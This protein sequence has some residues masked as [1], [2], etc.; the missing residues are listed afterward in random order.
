VTPDAATD[1]TATLAPPVHTGA[2]RR[3]AIPLYTLAICVSG[4]VYASVPIHMLGIIQAQGFSAQAA[5]AVAMI[6]GPA[7]VLSRIVEI[8]FG[9]RFDALVTG[10]VALAMLVLAML[11][12]GTV[13]GSASAI[14]FAALYGV[15]QGLITI[16]RGTVPLFLFGP[17]GYG[18]LVGRVTGLRLIVNAAG[19]FTFA[20]IV[21]QAGM[22][23]AITANAVAAALALCAFLALRRPAESAGA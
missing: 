3:R 12:I 20:W 18:A 2:A 23:A 17:D 14:G 1:A 13:G 5:A 9:R 22:P 6:M 7:Q 16:A 10:Q 4:I 11:L 8:A 15:S 19:P 21:T